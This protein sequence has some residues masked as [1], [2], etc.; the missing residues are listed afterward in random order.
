MRVSGGGGEAPVPQQ[1]L[2]LPYVPTPFIEEQVG[3]TVP[4]P[5]RSSTLQDG[6]VWDGSEPAAYARSFRLHALNDSPALAAQ[7]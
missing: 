1:F 5:M 7:R 2:Q 4:E 3:G 6:K